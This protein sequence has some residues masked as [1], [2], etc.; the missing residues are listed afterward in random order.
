LYTIADV[1]DGK[2]II[3]GTISLPAGRTAPA[4]G[5]E[6]RLMA[7][8]GEYNYGSTTVRIPGG[9]STVPF[10][11]NIKYH[12]PGYDYLINYR[13]MDDTI[14][15]YFKY[16][17]YGEN[18]IR[19]RKDMEAAFV[20][21]GASADEIDIEIPPFRTISGKVS[22][23]NGELAP[24]GGIELRIYAAIQNP[25][26]EIYIGSSTELIIPE[27]QNSADYMLSIGD[28]VD[29]N[30]LV[31]YNYEGEYIPFSRNGYY[32]SNGTT[33]YFSATPVY[34]DR[35]SIA[36]ID[37]TMVEGRF[38]TGKVSLLEGKVAPEGG[39][40]VGVGVSVYLPYLVEKGVFQKIE[41]DDP[42]ETGLYSSDKLFYDNG[43]DSVVIPEG[44]S[45][46]EYRVRI[47]PHSTDI[48][49]YISYR[50]YLGNGSRL[51]GY[52]KEGAAM[53]EDFDDITPVYA[54]KNDS[55]GNDLNVVLGKTISG[56]LSIPKGKAAPQKDLNIIV[57]AQSAKKS[58]ASYV[59]LERGSTEGY[60]IIAIPKDME[61]EEF[62]VSCYTVPNDEYKIG[63]YSVS[64]TTPLKSKASII[65]VGKDDLTDIDID[66]IPKN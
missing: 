41:T 2:N 24:K 33:D 48:P 28:N 47:L 46:A 58:Y 20:I 6:I 5:T 27:G 57:F 9:E 64:G 21:N 10:V 32:G 16:G 12:K 56:K 8:H 39:L 44:K 4:E 36:G 37:M 34:L 1:Q 65:N 45:S 18:G 53:T 29:T 31:A 66:L 30:F 60:Y 50:V 62:T 15:D 23:P 43:Y 54:G 35:E 19:I 55:N 7:L 11:I 22:L 51:R 14:V 17:Y 49:Y 63:Y 13:V 61:N 42:N 59:T 3:S 38:I 25:T 40:K 26:P 52:Y